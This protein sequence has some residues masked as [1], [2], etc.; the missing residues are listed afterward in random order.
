M[1]K[2]FILLA[3]FLLFSVLGVAQE[4]QPYLSEDEVMSSIR[5]LPPPPQEGSIEF[6]LDKIAY[7]EYYKLRTDNPERATQAIA[8]ADMSDIGDK[9]EGAFGF[10]VTEETMPETWLLLARSR[11]CFGSS[12]CN[13]AK[14]YY[15]R[16]RPFDYFGSHTL[17]PAD[18]EWLRANFSYPSGHTANYWGVGYIL[19]ELRPECSEAI[20]K[21]AEQGGISRLIVGAHWASDVAAGKMVA[22]SVFQFLKEDSEFQA[23]FKKAKLEVQSALGMT[24]SSVVESGKISEL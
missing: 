16:Q 13:E 14:K 1:K 7:F 18:D 22:A 24:D 19:A 20:L 17:T 12:G 5:L 2:V 15:K 21:R 23:Q 9:F 4:Y 6:L 11:E 3:E 8:D 10:R